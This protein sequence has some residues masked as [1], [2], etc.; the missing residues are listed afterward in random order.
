MEHQ[1][2]DDGRIKSNRG[3][4]HSHSLDIENKYLKPL[5][6]EIKKYSKIMAEQH[7]LDEECYNIDMWCNINGYKDYNISHNH[8]GCVF[9]GVYYVK[10]PPDCGNIVF[11]HPAQNVMGYAELDLKFKDYNAYNALTWRL[12][13]QENMMYVF[14]SWLKHCVDPNLSTENRISISFNYIQP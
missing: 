13:A 11:D 10:T 3:G 1:S 9:S 5:V 2:S 8:P 4:Y 12:P 6:E 7:T 14:P